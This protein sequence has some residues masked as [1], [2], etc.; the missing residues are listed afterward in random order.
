MRVAR[1][2][3]VLIQKRM[4]DMKTFGFMGHFRFLII[5]VLGGSFVLFGVLD[6]LRWVD[7]WFWAK[8]G[9][10]YFAV[11]VYILFYLNSRR[12]GN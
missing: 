11:F 5:M 10:S 9:L 3:F 8:A 4:I 6:F 7:Q 12:K 1:S 2:H